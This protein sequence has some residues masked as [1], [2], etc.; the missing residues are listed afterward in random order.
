MLLLDVETG[1]GVLISVDSTEIS[2]VN[3]SVHHS[4]VGRLN[5]PVQKAQL[6]KL[7][8]HIKHL[9]SCFSKHLIPFLLSPGFN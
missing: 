6:M 8:D 9:N 7:L 2:Q 1:V 5:V 3:L 4:K